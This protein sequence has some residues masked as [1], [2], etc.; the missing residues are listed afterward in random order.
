MKQCIKCKEL[1]PVG[2]YYFK[3]RSKNK[4]IGQCRNCF[5]DA[6]VFRNRTKSGLVKLMLR[7]QKQS[8]KR[9]GYS[10]PDYSGAMLQEWCFNQEVFHTLYDEWVRFD[11]D[12]NYKPSI[13][14]RDD[15]EAYSFDNIVLTTYRENIDRSYIDRKSGKNGKVNKIVERFDLDG[16][17]VD[18]FPSKNGVLRKLNISGSSLDKCLKTKAL[19][20]GY[21]YRYR[22]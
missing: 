1:K 19:F 10:P 16:V 9:R 20:R 15:Y 8:S 11:Y 13:D 6:V 5:D 22:E 14:R 17:Y 2:D 7:G 12:T 21:F 18:C 4:L 3:D